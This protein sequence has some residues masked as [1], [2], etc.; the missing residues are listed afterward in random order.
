M[1]YVSWDG[2]IYGKVEF[3]FG[4]G[5]KVGLIG[6]VWNMEKIGKNRWKLGSRFLGEW[7]L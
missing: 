3:V 4:V 1:R 2:V 6:W 7:K 5:I